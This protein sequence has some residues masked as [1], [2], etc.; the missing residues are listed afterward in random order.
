M[1]RFLNIMMAMDVNNGMGMNNKLP[2][3]LN[4]D[5]RWFLSISTTTKDPLKRNAVII[6]RLTF[7]SFCKYLTKNFIHWH[8]IVITSNSLESIKANYEQSH[9]DVVRSFDEAVRMARGFLDNSEKGIESVFVFGGVHPYE[10]AM[11]SGLV[12]RVYLTRIFAE[13]P[14][15]TYWSSLDLSQ[16]R[17]IQR[18]KNEIL[19]ELDDQIIGENGVTYQFQVYEFDEKQ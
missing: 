4:E 17:R 9:I 19:A 18:S 13:Y 3:K 6:G 2:W 5:E 11:A 8:F 10:Q 7:E 16:F 12:Y 1:H 15:D 14:C